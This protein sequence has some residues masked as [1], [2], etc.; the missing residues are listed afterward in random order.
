[1]GKKAAVTAKN[2]LLKYIIPVFFICLGASYRLGEN[3]YPVIYGDEFG[4]WAAGSF[5]AGL[6]W[7]DVTAI[8]KYYGY[9]YGLLLA[10]I[11]LVIKNIFAAYKAA[12]IINIIMLAFCY[13]I[14]VNLTDRYVKDNG[15][16]INDAAKI[17]IAFF[18]SCYPSYFHLAQ[19]TMAEIPTLLCTWA[20]IWVMYGYLS[21]NSRK[22]YAILLVLLSTLSFMIHLR[23][24]AMVA[25]VLF[26]MVL[27]QMLGK[28]KKQIL[29]AA[30]ITLLFAL[31]I[32][33]SLLIKNYYIS[34]YYSFEAM[35]DTSNEFSGGAAKFSRILSVSGIYNSVIGLIGKLYYLFAAGFGFSFFAFAEGI[36]NIRQIRAKDNKAALF[37]FFL[38]FMTILYI[39]LNI[40]NFTDVS[41]RFDYLTYGRYFE[42]VIPP[43]MMMGLILICGQKISLRNI[44]IYY[45][46]FLAISL[47]T[48]ALQD[49]S[50]PTANVF[51]CCSAISK[52]LIKSG[53]KEGT[54]LAVGVFACICFALICF[55]SKKKRLIGISILLIVLSIY[56]ISVS[57]YVIDNGEYS[58]SVSENQGDLELYEYILNEGSAD[59]IYYLAED[60]NRV[61]DGI[62]YLLRDHK[63]KVITDVN[64][65]KHILTYRKS[66]YASEMEKLGY[67]KVLETRRLIYW[68]PAD[69]ESK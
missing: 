35:R 18:V 59:N 34:S 21:E 37:G 42:N 20:I 19:Y 46:V 51:I 10:V 62:Q 57:H 5:F 26:V 30:G 38:S 24:I 48:E 14:A 7:G 52:A 32:V 44:G 25:A 28:Q 31:G 58:W 53:F 15:L 67:D 4:Y 3:L 45:A 6:D 27:K 9:G 2:L 23:N 1:M 36:K 29:S 12:L 40:V 63:I 60:E 49:Y 61:V 56:E 41:A 33:F 13:I 16:K 47:F 50:L 66:L 55:F 8:N 64:G 65:E 22:I 43:L 69:D 68:E 54:L 17:C 11:L 39:G